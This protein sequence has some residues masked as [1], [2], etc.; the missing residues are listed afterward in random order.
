MKVYIRIFVWEE[1]DWSVKAGYV[2]SPEK[3]KKVEDILKSD[4]KDGLINWYRV[5][6]LYGYNIDP[7]DLPNIQIK[8]ERLVLRE[9]A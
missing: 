1:D 3:A 6:K 9:Q 8:D 2:Y 4:L 7:I 5:F